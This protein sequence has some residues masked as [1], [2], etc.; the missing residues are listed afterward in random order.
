[1]PIIAIKLAAVIFQIIEQGKHKP[2]WSLFYNDNPNRRQTSA[3]RQQAADVFY[4]GTGSRRCTYRLTTFMP[5]GGADL[6]STV[7]RTVLL[8]D[9]DDDF[10]VFFFF[11]LDMTSDP[12]DRS[13]AT[14]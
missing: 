4:P 12:G 5:V 1:M 10:T 3:R 2:K 6:R 13:S 9:N 8:D 11:A 14:A 7:R